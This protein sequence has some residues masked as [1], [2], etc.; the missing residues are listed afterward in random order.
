MSRVVAGL[1]RIVA[2]VVALALIAGG[3]AA[4][5]WR[6]GKLPN[7]GTVVSASW[8]PT[9]TE[10][11]WWP[12]VTAAAG[13]ILVLLGLWWLL[14]HLPGGKVGSVPLPGSNA[15]GR[16][17]VDLSAVAAA[18]ADALA[19]E[20]GV[21]S[22]NG[23]AVNDRGRRTVQIVTTVEPSADLTSVAVAADQMCADLAGAVGEGMATRVHVHVTRG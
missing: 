1:D 8:A 5:A 10:Q 22:A 14:S 21:E 15:T 23:K 12:W 2:L 20:P 4:I 7:V 9:L 19:C 18:A 11:S 17:R 3:L 13:V 6:F 16:L